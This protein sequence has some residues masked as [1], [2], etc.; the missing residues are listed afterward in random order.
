MLHLLNRKMFKFWP[1]SRINSIN[2]ERLFRLLL[3]EKRIFQWNILR[4]WKKDNFN[5]SEGCFHSNILHI[6]GNKI[7]ECEEKVQL[8]S[9]TT[10]YFINKCTETL[11]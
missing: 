11:Q 8:E 7:K 5:K 6:N 1:T 10:I 4:Y 3:E 2:N 9:Q